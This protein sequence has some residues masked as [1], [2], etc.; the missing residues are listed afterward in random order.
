V[1]FSN[2]VWCFLKRG[3]SSAF[4][5]I[6]FIPGAIIGQAPAALLNRGVRSTNNE[7]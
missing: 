4:F 6:F 7:I 5:V 3:E 2:G 1:V